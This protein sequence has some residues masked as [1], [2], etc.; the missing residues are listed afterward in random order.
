M[1]IKIIKKLLIIFTILIGLAIA[2]LAVFLLFFT[3]PN[4]FKSQITEQVYKQTGLHFQVDG[5][6]HWVFDPQLGMS[7]T[8]VTIVPMNGPRMVVKSPRM[9]IFVALKPLISGKIVI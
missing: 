5:P 4:H 1:I 8:S 7:F 3:N 2:I 9:D 6:I